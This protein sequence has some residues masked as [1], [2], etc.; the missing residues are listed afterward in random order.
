MTQLLM[1]RQKLQKE[2]MLDPSLALY[3][4]LY[5]P[6]GVSFM[7]KD[8]YGHLCTASGALWTPQGRA[9]GGV[10]DYIDCG[11]KDLFSFTDGVTDIPFSIEAWI[12]PD[13]IA[14]TRQ[15]CSK[16]KGG[17]SYEWVFRLTSGKLTIALSDSA[18]FGNRIGRQYNT[19]ISITAFSHVMA[20]YDGTE[21]EGG[22]SLY[23][24]GIRVDDTAFS[25][26]VYPG[27]TN[28]AHPL[29]IG[30][31]NQPLEYFS[32]TIGELR[33]YRYPALSVG[34]R[35]RNY[36]MTKWRYQ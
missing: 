11:D 7:S 14:G 23:L 24:N 4:P 29:E 32:G 28:L 3:L 31:Q 6:D 30:R 2:F 20:I 19:V 27:M 9:F 5:E 36:Q 8:R 12:K 18:N 13:N 16:F 15:I 33:I 10:A 34:E 25:A 35:I 1:P 22:L 21:L 26:G 17:I